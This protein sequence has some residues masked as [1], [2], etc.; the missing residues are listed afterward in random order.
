MLQQQLIVCA[1]APC[2]SAYFHYLLLVVATQKQLLCTQPNHFGAVLS[3]AP[4]HTHTYIEMHKYI[5]I[6]FSMPK[7]FAYNKRQLFVVLISFLHIKTFQ[8]NS[9]AV[10]FKA[11]FWLWYYFCCCCCFHVSQTSVVSLRLIELYYQS[12]SRQW[13]WQL[14]CG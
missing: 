5:R 9:A 3:V 6:S 4:T 10:I 8:V 11:L 1:A 13:L 12:I 2:H 14:S 7:R